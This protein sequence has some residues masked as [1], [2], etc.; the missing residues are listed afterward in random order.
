MERSGDKENHSRTG[1][2]TNS[3]NGKI[4]VFPESQIE[5]GDHQG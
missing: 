2:T 5:L 1:G 4:E 3:C